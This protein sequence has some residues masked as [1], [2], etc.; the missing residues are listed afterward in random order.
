MGSRSTTTTESGTRREARCRNANVMPDIGTPDTPAA[1]PQVRGYW[2]FEGFPIL[3]TTAVGIAGHTPG[4]NKLTITEV[5]RKIQCPLYVGL[6]ISWLQQAGLKISYLGRVTGE[7]RE[8]ARVS[9][10]QNT[11]KFG[12]TL[13]KYNRTRGINPIR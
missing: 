3:Q 7:M 1:V 13:T 8:P 11:A 10:F 2:S 5:F 12:F 6:R 4:S 9:L